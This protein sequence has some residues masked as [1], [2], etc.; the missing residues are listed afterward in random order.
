VLTAL[1]CA[2]WSLPAQKPA[3]PPVDPYTDAKPAAM[4]KVAVLGYGPFAIGDQHGSEQVDALVGAGRMIWLETRHFRLGSSLPAL[5]WP[6]ESRLRKQLYEE[7]RLLH[8]LLPAFASE[9]AEL[10]RWLHLHLFAQRLEALYDD[11]RRRLGVDDAWFAANPMSEGRGTG[12]NL[13]CSGKFA[14]LLFGQEAELGRYLRRYC[15]HAVDEPH[16]HW[17]RGADSVV[18]ATSLDARSGRLRDA[19]LLAAHV[20]DAVAGMLVAAY[21]GGLDAVPW[22]FD[23][24]VGHWYARRLHPRSC[25]L[26]QLQDEEFAAADTWEWESRVR[27]RV[28]RNLVLP[29][30]SLVAL[31]DDKDRRPVD[32]LQLWSCVDFLFLQGEAETVRWFRYLRAHPLRTRLMPAALAERWHEA[33]FRAALDCSLADAEA[34]WRKFALAQG[35]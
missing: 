9:P 29:W 26:G 21:A 18:F 16:R 35:R 5:P 24:G 27:A 25:E 32:H 23:V 4:Q 30:K 6:E 12:T 33:A 34:R 10:D 28:H 3:T 15:E 31:A 19:T 1:L 8:K 17:F 20:Q 13:G 2:A 7:C 22:W 11:V 14:V